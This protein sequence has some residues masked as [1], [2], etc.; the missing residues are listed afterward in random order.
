MRLAAIGTLN[1]NFQQIWLNYSN[2]IK[3]RQD[4]HHVAKFR[5]KY[6]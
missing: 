4:R 2:S 5:Y 1:Q 6:V 3:I